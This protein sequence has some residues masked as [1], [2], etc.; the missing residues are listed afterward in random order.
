MGSPGR[1]SDVRFRYSTPSWKVSIDELSRS[2]PQV[3]H[4]TPEDTLFFS[5]PSPSNM[6]LP[7]RSRQPELSCYWF[8]VTVLFLAWSNQESTNHQPVSAQPLSSQYCFTLF[9]DCQREDKEGYAAG[10]TWPTKLKI[11]L[12]GPLQKKFSH[13]WPILYLYFWR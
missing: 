12:F 13:S 10:C 4:Q 6:P 3:M 9:K 11:L 8:Q 2:S 7:F 5:S 1:N